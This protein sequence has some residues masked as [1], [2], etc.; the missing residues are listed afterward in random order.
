MDLNLAV[1]AFATAIAYAEGFYVNGSRP[2]RNHNPGD[3]TI[4]TVGLGVGKD[5]PFIVYAN[6]ADGWTAL[7]RQ[8]QLI[9]TNTSSIYN[10]DM[11]IQDMANRYTATDQAAWA[12]NVAGKLGVSPDTKI[13]TIL[14]TATTGVGA[15]I[16]LIALVMYFRNKK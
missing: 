15:I 16:V 11:T 2:Q 9:L 7:K 4:D 6:D 3:L 14:A 1:N 8:V 10:T 12:L 13:S 5:G